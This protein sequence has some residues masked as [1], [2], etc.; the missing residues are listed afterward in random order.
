MKSW[1]KLKREP[2]LLSFLPFDVVER[3]F[4]TV[5]RDLLSR[6]YTDPHSDARIDGVSLLDDRDCQIVVSVS[7][8]VQCYLSQK[9]WD[10]YLSLVQE[11]SQ[12]VLR[13][14]HD[15]ERWHTVE[16]IV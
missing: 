5:E 2:D 14:P 11:R 8:V 16:V 13:A 7:V 4:A 3:V 10:E 1:A 6:Y 15:I 12:Y 9:Q